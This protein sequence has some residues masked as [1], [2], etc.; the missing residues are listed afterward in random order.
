MPS[1]LQCQKNP[2]QILREQEISTALPAIRVNRVPYTVRNYI[3]KKM[4]SILEFNVCVDATFLSAA[5]VCKMAAHQSIY[6]YNLETRVMM[7]SAKN[8]F[9]YIETIYKYE[10]F[11]WCAWCDMHRKLTKI[12]VLY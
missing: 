8:I 6:T 3:E 9:D 2:Y 1:A 12:G 7:H 11:S 4:A 5:K 10:L